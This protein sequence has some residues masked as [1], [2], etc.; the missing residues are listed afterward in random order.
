[1]AT[2][3]AIRNEKGKYCSRSCV[4]WGKHPFTPEERFMNLLNK[5][6]NGC[7]VWKAKTSYPKFWYGTEKM[8][9]SQWSYIHWKGPLEKG[10]EVC[11]TC[12][13]PRCVNPEHLFLGTHQ[14]NMKDAGNKGRLS[15]LAKLES[16]RDR[17]QH[18]YLESEKQ[19]NEL[20]NRLK[21][22]I[23]AL[24]DADGFIVGGDLKAIAD[25]LEKPL[26]K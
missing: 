18:L 24:R 19:K 17:Y 10:K 23:A 14:E 15:W 22:S 21:R 12:D 26:E 9:A 2:P 20:A 6:P 5:E 13:N 3:Y 8:K 25:E 16:D 4:K 1:M 11:H 7:W